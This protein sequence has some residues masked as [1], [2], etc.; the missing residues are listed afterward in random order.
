M[1]DMYRGE[2]EDT[3]GNIINFDIQD[4]GGRYLYDFPSMGSVSIKS[5]DA[6][7]IV[8]SLTD[9]QSWEEAYNLRDMIIDGKVVILLLFSNLNN[10]E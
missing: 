3:S 2:F 6:F 1:D 9:P 4:V 10:A 7:I 8:V 5:A